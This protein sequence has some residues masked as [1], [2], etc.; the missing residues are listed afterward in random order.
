[1]KRWFLY[2]MVLLLAVAA[3]VT[4]VVGKYSGTPVSV[5]PLTFPETT[6]EILV[7]VDRLP[8]NP[9]YAHDIA[10][11][12]SIG[13]RYLTPHTSWTYIDS[14]SKARVRAATA[15]VYL[16][17][18]GLQPLTAGEADVL[19]AAHKLIVCQHHLRELREYRVAFASVAGAISA[20]PPA[21][22][23]MTYRNAVAPA[24]LDEFLRFSTSGNA[25][26]LADYNLPAGDRVPA[27]IT[28]GSVLFLN[29]PLRFD[30]FSFE[31]VAAS[32]AIASFLG[33]QPNPQPLAMLRLEDVSALT[34][35]NRMAAIAFYLWRAHVPYGVG[36]IPDLQVKNGAGGALRN[37]PALV[38]V[39]R[40]AQNHGATIILHG[41][42]HCCSSENSEG[43]EFWDH[44]R[45]V[46]V[47][48]DSI[49]WM[50]AT[51]SK[52]LDEERSL[53]L[54]PMMWETP[55]Y[56]ASPLDYTVLRQSFPVAWE[57]RNP[58]QWIPWPLQRD[59]Y[60]ARILP[61]NLGYVALDG[62]HTVSDQ[63]NR[64]QTMLACRY[65]VVAGFIH[66][67]LIDVSQVDAYVQGLRKMGYA[68]VDPRQAIVAK[69]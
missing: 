34:P 49:A 3:I 4:I 28:D 60:G 66:P 31:T 18:D 1:M 24:N 51:V 8:G 11:Q 59:E 55:H 26:V 36:V 68:F 7:L 12:V 63:L 43:Y 65:C 30:T 39:L 32:D 47:A 56:A 45:R 50:T 40:W 9:R 17:I 16:G 6:G 33:I 19:R 22:M 64:A 2:P 13:L 48:G 15:V 37:N 67:A 62:S 25:T 58:A 35:A 44:D 5:V 27:I 38:A 53:G 20:D 61:E 23:T 14:A 10:D 29:A 41:L 52:G 42:H 69:N 54:E 46:P 57:E 21:D